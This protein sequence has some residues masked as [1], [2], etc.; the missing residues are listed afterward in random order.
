MRCGATE[1]NRNPQKGFAGMKRYGGKGS[2]A[3]RI[4]GKM[5]SG[6]LISVKETEV[7]YLCDVPPENTT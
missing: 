6:G 4:V 1:E 7:G 5:T 2:A 3:G